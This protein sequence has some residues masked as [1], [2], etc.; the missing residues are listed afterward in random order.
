MFPYKGGLNKFTVYTP[1][2]W[3]APL[4][5]FI[6][7]YDYFRSGRLHLKVCFDPL[8]VQN[9][10]IPNAMFLNN[11]WSGVD[12]SPDPEASE[13]AI[14]Y[15]QRYP[16]RLLLELLQDKQ[17]MAWWVALVGTYQ[18]SEELLNSAGMDKFG[19]PL[20]PAQPPQTAPA[21]IDLTLGKDPE[22]EAIYNMSR[23]G[24]VVQMS[25]ELLGSSADSVLSLPNGMF[26]WPVQI[27]VSFILALLSTLAFTGGPRTKNPR[28][29]FA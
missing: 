3:G 4:G 26:D 19:K 18:V 10:K 22:A 21:A 16:C 17:L 14:V 15:F 20:N 7:S 6:D 27:S 1:Q 2:T 5:V 28:P 24:Q 11:D 29:Q 9:I 25:E 12:R 8:V 23:Q 13:A